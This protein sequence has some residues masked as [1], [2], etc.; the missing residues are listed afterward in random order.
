[1]NYNKCAMPFWQHI[2]A[3]IVFA[4]VM[5][6]IMYVF[7]RN[8]VISVIMGCAVAPFFESSFA[9]STIKKRKKQLRAQF[10]DM[11][12]SMSVA[13]RAGNNELKS[14]ESAYKDLKMI[15]SEKA[16]ILREIETILLKNKSGIQLRV[17]FKD[18]GERSGVEDIKSFA[19]I[20]EVIEG[21]SNKFSDIIR[22]TQQIISDK[23]EIESEIETIL[24][25]P[26][27]E[28]TV[29]MV[30]P[31]LLVLIMS[32]GGGG[33]LEIL[34]TTLTGRLLTTVCVGIFIGAYFLGLKM[35]DIKV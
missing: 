7:Y 16:D 4:A 32:M 20:F 13:S 33:F 28:M 19:S 8:W 15:Y 23:I 21:K 18:F 24:T 9:K 27:S 10:C 11:L 29:L 2:L 30:M 1:M 6:V 22:Q 35:T 31:V 5:A 26:K 3:Y 12:E 25:A 34:F 17:L 14:L